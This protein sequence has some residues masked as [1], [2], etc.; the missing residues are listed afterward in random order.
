MMK[1]SR[2]TRL[3]LWLV[4]G[5]AGM[6]GLAYASVPLYRLF[7]QVTGFNG[8]TQ[9]ASDAPDVATGK[10]VRVRFDTNINGIDW[11]FT[12]EKPSIRMEVGKTAMVEFKVKN[13]ADHPV[14]GRA[15]YNVLPETTG[16]YFMKL[17]CFCFTDQTLEAGEEKSFP[18]LFYIDPELLKDVETR[19]VADLTL[20]YTFFEVTKKE[21]G[22][23][24]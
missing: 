23:K 21:S 6:G 11:S 17:Q 20:S 13:H 19:D 3:V 4:L 2:N 15:I 7:C 5:C 9:V 14:T 24:K 12:P 8:T 16:S 10:F 18:M 22:A 1:L